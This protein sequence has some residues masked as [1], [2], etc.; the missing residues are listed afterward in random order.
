MKKAKTDAVCVN[1]LELF[2]HDPSLNTSSSPT[3]YVICDSKLEEHLFEY[4]S[5][6][7]PS[8]LEEVSSNGF[9]KYNANVE[10]FQAK[11]CKQFE[12]FICGG[13]T[14][15][16]IQELARYSK[17]QK[18][19]GKV[20][21][22]GDLTY[23]CKTCAQD[24][25][26]VF[27]HFC[28]YQSIHKNHRYKL[29]ASCG[30]GGYCD[31]GDE[32]AW[33]TDPACDYHKGGMSN[34]E[35]WDPFLSLPV[36]V[37]CR[38]TFIFK[39]VLQYCMELLVMEEHDDINEDI[40]LP[41]TISENE[42]NNSYIVML[43]NDE[44]HTY[45]EVI[46]TLTEAIKCNRQQ[47]FHL[48]AIVDKE[49]RS[50]IYTGEAAE[51]D[52]VVTDCKRLTTRN[53]KSPLKCKSMHRNVVTHQII[54]LDLMTWMSEII[55]ISDGLRRLLCLLTTVRISGLHRKWS[56]SF[57]EM[58]IRQDT[59]LWKVARARSHQLFMNVVLM[60]TYGRRE[61]A[62]TFAKCYKLMIQDF[63]VDDHEHSISVAALSVQIFT[64][65]SL[66]TMLILDGNILKTCLESFLEKVQ[67]AIGKNG[68]LDFQES[69][70]AVNI[71]RANYILNDVL[72][73]LRHKPVWTPQLSTN[74]LDAFD[75]FLNILKLM[76]GMDSILRKTQTHV[77][78]EPNW[79]T[80][81][82]LQLG[83]I[84]VIRAMLV[85]CCSD[86]DILKATTHRCVFTL[87]SLQPLKYTTVKKK[88]VVNHDVSTKLVSIHFAL[89]R[90][91]AGLLP[92][93]SKY[94]FSLYDLLQ[95]EMNPDDSMI[96]L[97]LQLLEYP[98]RSLVLSA[99]VNA[100][101]WKRN[102]YAIHHQSFC[103]HNV[104]FVSEMSDR[105]ILMLQV[106]ACIMSPDHFIKALLHKYN[107]MNWS[108]GKP[109]DDKDK[110]KEAAEKE[111]IVANDFLLVIFYVLSERYV[112]GVSGLTTTQIL[113]REIIHKLCLGPI[114]RSALIKNLP[115]KDSEDEDDCPFESQIDGILNE[116]AIY[117]EPGVTG[118]GVFELKE[119]AL[120]K[121][122]KFFM[123]FTKAEQSKM[124]EEKKRISRKLAKSQTS[125]LH[126]PPKFLENFQNIVKLVCCDSLL[127]LLRVVLL[128]AIKEDR[129][130][131]NHVEEVLM[132]IAVGLIEVKRFRG[133]TTMKEFNFLELLRK[134]KSAKSI[135]SLIDELTLNDAKEYYP[136]AKWVKQLLQ[137]EIEYGGVTQMDV[138]SSN[139]ETSTITKDD[140]KAEKARMVSERKKKMMEQISQMQKAFMK[141][142]STLFDICN[143]TEELMEEDI[144]NEDLSHPVAV[145]SR[146]SAVDN[147]CMSVLCI[148][149]QEEQTIDGENFF[150]VTSFV[151]KSNIIDKTSEK[152]RDQIIPELSKSNMV[153][154][155]SCGHIVH[156]QCWEKYYTSVKERESLPY[157]QRRPRS[158]ID[159]SQTEYLCPLCNSLCNSVLPL[160]PRAPV[161][162]CSA[163]EDINQDM[164]LSEFLTYLERFSVE[165]M[166]TPKKVD[167]TTP[168]SRPN[169]SPSWT[170]VFTALL[171]SYSRSDSGASAET[172]MELFPKKL[173]KVYG[174]GAENKPVSYSVPYSWLACSFTLQAYECSTRLT[175]KNIFSNISERKDKFWHALIQYLANN[176][177]IGVYEPVQH[178]GNVLFNFFCG[179]D[180]EISLSILDADLFSILISLRFLVGCIQNIFQ[181]EE[182]RLMNTSTCLIDDVVFKICL[183]ANLVKIYLTT[184]LFIADEKSVDEEDNVVN[185]WLYI[186][187]LLGIKHTCQIDG[188][189]L[190]EHV[191]ES[192]LPFMRCSAV[193]FHYLTGVKLPDNLSVDVAVDEMN[194]LQKYLN[195]TEGT[196]AILSLEMLTC[197]PLVEKMVERWCKHEEVTQQLQSITDVPCYM[198]A[199]R[200][201]KLPKDYSTLINRVSGFMCPTLTNDSS[202]IPAL[203]LV[204]DTILCSQCYCCVNETEPTQ[205]YGACSNHSMECSTGI[206]IFLRVRDCEIVLMY[207]RSK[208]SFL[209]SPYLDEYGETDRG[210]RR[211]NPL[212]LNEKRYEYIEQLWL[213]QKIPETIAQAMESN[214]GPN[215]HDW[216]QL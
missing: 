34:D 210:F 86:A 10:E 182:P 207:N 114:S 1:W 209:P 13:I 39:F 47:A 58:I 89:S 152:N 6:V 92:G 143:E 73:L 81:F 194:T 57:L 9:L 82:N 139:I 188:H 101:M 192:L 151:H 109:T 135:H 27:C 2:A 165:V 171:T 203:C 104:R 51:S 32:E 22:V 136:I 23:T 108:K 77:A 121:C 24:P 147:S 117:R 96:K 74:F 137:E 103:Y 36:D 76:Q 100:Q 175:G 29:H 163:P 180:C 158:C 65:P 48:A 40:I 90:F 213:R 157:F 172:F 204:C 98:M 52:V 154:V 196:N 164:S 183:V 15:N 87:R 102:G 97:Q 35:S 94:G 211:G 12:H 31:C 174:N 46:T 131:E 193:F 142:N 140:E 200:L 159:I 212:Y 119:E 170:S 208:G 177:M 17:P 49:G 63:I 169:S 78:Y 206:G 202:R 25:T 126:T 53:G 72:Y 38:A 132:I 112:T 150:V 106:L 187:N 67:P 160:L 95:M 168:P 178:F 123:H 3:E 130:S 176:C 162:Q 54:A 61:F 173:M 18:F 148:L 33:T 167:N 156:I 118:K 50:S 110:D 189:K 161:Y 19:C 14:D 191:L 84:P 28:F 45:E 198:H 144:I 145:G 26:C 69:T 80:A 185:S 59:S 107:L 181:E 134:E 113:E 44:S 155:S 66:A 129:F 216:H 149:C 21:N 141:N 105:D 199:R 79:E 111:S 197:D 55:E 11:V 64:V 214:R 201:I 62:I 68:N 184:P 166:C 122:N 138:D 179:V 120:V 71:T 4:F 215:A 83:I 125:Y 146:H 42:S 43:Y 153:N 7:V 190:K 127:K 88:I 133:D 30:T 115:Y 37:Q 85:W 195:L 8:L 75:V 124:M 116:V 205:R 41:I 70:T 56:M 5:S 16:G 186:Q 93:S 128:R 60:D 91:L 99:Q 20:F